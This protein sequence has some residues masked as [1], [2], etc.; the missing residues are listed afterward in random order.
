MSTLNRQVHFDSITPNGIVVKAKNG[1]APAAV[2]Y[3]EALS[4]VF[5]NGLEMAACGHSKQC[6]WKSLAKDKAFLKQLQYKMSP[7]VG[8]R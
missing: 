4:R 7:Y 5:S 3:A 1:A 6:N 2:R 8:E